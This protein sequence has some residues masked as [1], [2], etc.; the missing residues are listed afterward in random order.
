[1]SSQRKTRAEL[2]EEQ[3]NP[4][5]VTIMVEGIR[6]VVTWEEYQQFLT[7]DEPP[8]EEVI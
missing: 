8:A 7:G 1:M 3:N 4:Q 5:N 6:K 2:R